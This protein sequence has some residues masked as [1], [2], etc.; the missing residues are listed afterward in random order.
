MTIKTSE[1]EVLA[2][3]SDIP[4]SQS[5]LAKKLGIHRSNVTGW[6][7]KL[8]DKGLAQRTSNGQW[9]RSRTQQAQQQNNDRT[10]K[11]KMAVRHYF[12]HLDAFKLFPTTK[13]VR[14]HLDELMDCENGA[15]DTK[16]DEFYDELYDIY[17]N[18]TDTNF[19]KKRYRDGYKELR[20]KYGYPMPNLRKK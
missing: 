15:F 14:K 7:H 17:N 2:C 6:L 12:V 9:V 3:L 5:D 10:E 16:F 19:E 11:L 4:Q 1:E 13:L 20:D 8:E 18:R